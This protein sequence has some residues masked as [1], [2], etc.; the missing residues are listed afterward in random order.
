MA[1]YEKGKSKINVFYGIIIVLLLACC[2][3]SYCVTGNN[4]FSDML[5]DTGTSVSS[6][7]YKMSVHFLNVGKADCAYIN[8]GDKNILIDA[9]DKDVSNNVREYLKRQNVEKLDLV[10][11]SHAHR[12]HIGQMDD[13]I[14]NFDIDKF[15]MP[16]IPNKIVPTSR[17]YVSMLK[18]LDEKKVNVEIAK[19]G[20][21]FS[22]GD[23]VIDIFAPCGIYDDINNT[24]IVMKITFGKDSFL[25]TGDASEQSELDMIKR[26]FDL[27]STVLKVGHHGSRTS[28]TWK[29]LNAVSPD[30]A[31]ISV[32][33]D[34][35]NL[36]NERIIKRLNSC[37]I[38]TY[39][40]DESGN[41][42]CCTNGD[43]VTFTTEREEK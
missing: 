29:F 28:S 43:G 6:K 16:D 22:I 39:R 12:D 33:K 34:K 38:K 2:A 27:K 41:I 1:S 11:M 8:C 7:D 32:K 9:A 4:P 25:F 23:M 5:E 40:T 17:T 36:P 21:R 13:V 3:Y 19:V 37:N 31:V 26:G 18:A 15:L 14:K 10:V 42:V 30:Y 24:S 35:S 20:S